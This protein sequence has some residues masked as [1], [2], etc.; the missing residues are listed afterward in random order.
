VCGVRT[1][2]L[3]HLLVLFILLGHPLRGRL[4]LNKVLHESV[5][6]DGRLW[7]SLGDL[8]L[9]ELLLGGQRTNLAVEG[10]V[11]VFGGCRATGWSVG[12]RVG[13][14]EGKRGEGKARKETYVEVAWG[15]RRKAVR[16]RGGWE[17]WGQRVDHATVCAWVKRASAGELGGRG[18]EELELTSM[19]L[20]V[21]SSFMPAWRL[22]SS[23][24]W[25]IA[26]RSVLV[27]LSL[28][29]SQSFVESRVMR[30]KGEFRSIVGCGLPASRVK[31]SFHAF[32]LTDI[33]SRSHILSSTAYIHPSSSRMPSSSPLYSS[34]P[35]EIVALEREAE[36]RERDEVRV[37]VED[38]RKVNKIWKKEC[39]GESSCKVLVSDR[40]YGSDSLGCS[41]GA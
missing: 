22:P 29:R 35:L 24:F 23:T 39:E 33:N 38:L 31:C 5:N 14:K 32:P 4:P 34:Q 10:F 7:P 17:L 8:D 9:D 41:D 12:A 11:K 36:K 21:T 15:T 6:G 27:I 18:K 1:D 20:W 13:G 26:C 28:I 3:F 30:E 2:P 40:R 19:V 16:P 25:S 37:Q